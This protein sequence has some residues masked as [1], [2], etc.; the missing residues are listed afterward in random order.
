MLRLNAIYINIVS[1]KIW[2][3]EILNFFH[4]KKKITPSQGKIRFQHKI[5]STQPYVS[6]T[7]IIVHTYKII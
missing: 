1:C 7:E 3:A 2:F 6:W 5:T 4:R